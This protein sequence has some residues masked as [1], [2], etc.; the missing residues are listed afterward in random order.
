MCLDLIGPKKTQESNKDYLSLKSVTIINPVTGWI[1][2][3]KY[4]DNQAITIVNLVETMWLT[5]Y[6]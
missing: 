4:K 2:V 3:T 1:G 5:R 6:P